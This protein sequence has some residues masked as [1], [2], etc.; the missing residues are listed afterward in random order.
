[1]FSKSFLNS[2]EVEHFEMREGGAHLSLSPT[3]TQIFQNALCIVHWHNQTSLQSS[4]C[5]VCLQSIY[6]N[7]TVG[8]CSG[9]PAS[10]CFSDSSWVIWGHTMCALMSLLPPVMSLM[11]FLTSTCGGGLCPSQ[12]LLVEGWGLLPKILIYR[13]FAP[14]EFPHLYHWSLYSY[15]SARE[16]FETTHTL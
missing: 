5:Q 6:D 13:C 15:V 8:S 3:P 1:M 16:V 7:A 4:Q 14:S 11:I 10:W 9:G 12:F 2:E